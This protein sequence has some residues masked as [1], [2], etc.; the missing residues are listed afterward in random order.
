MVCAGFC[1]VF[2]VSLLCWV[3]S[4]FGVAWCLIGLE[5][6]ALGY[7]CLGDVLGVGLRVLVCEF[8]VFA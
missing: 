3:F 1:A 4:L 5:L 8:C 7:G 2:D 6:N